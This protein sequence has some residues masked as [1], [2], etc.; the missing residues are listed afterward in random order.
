MAAADQLRIGDH[1][2]TIPAGDM[3]ATD[4]I[5]ARQVADV[6]AVLRGASHKLGT[7]RHHLEG[8]RPTDP[9]SSHDPDVD[10]MR[11]ALEYLADP[12]NWL[13][14]PHHMTAILEGDATPHELAVEALRAS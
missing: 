4:E 12:S 11:R 8:S 9:A 10:R 5:L 6:E 14:N 2:P 13:S 3:F 7:V 1:P